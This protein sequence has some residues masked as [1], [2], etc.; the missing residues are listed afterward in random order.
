MEIFEITKFI[1]LLGVL[2]WVGGIIFTIIVNRNLRKYMDTVEAT[3]TLSVIGKSI[4]FSMRLGLIL[5]ILSGI[6]LLVLRKI[7]ILDFEFYRTDIG[8]LILIKYIVVL[9]FILVLPYHSKIGSVLLK[10]K[11]FERFRKLRNLLVFLG[12][13]I[14]GFSFIAMYIG[15]KIRYGF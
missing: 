3:K 5:A 10:E 6:L 12:W 13:L 9:I 8:K 7:P 14:L 4:Q 2:M 1:H 15:T 11:D